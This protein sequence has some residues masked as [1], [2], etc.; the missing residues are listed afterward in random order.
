MNYRTHYGGKTNDTYNTSLIKD[1][2]SLPYLI[3]SEGW[4]DNLH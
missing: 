3:E 1:I 4:V 2:L